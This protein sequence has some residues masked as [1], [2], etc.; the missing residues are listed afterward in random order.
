LLFKNTCSKGDIANIASI[1]LLHIYIE[2]IVMYSI[3]L[4]SILKC[5]QR[6]A[7]FIV[8]WKRLK[9]LF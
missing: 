9:V 1:F 7:R 3:W 6:F 2:D 8:L 4:S 5:V